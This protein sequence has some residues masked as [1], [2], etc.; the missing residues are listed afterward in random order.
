VGSVTVEVA[1]A[2]SR[3]DEIELAMLDQPEAIDD[4]RPARDAA[5]ADE[6]GG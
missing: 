6:A 1:R 4:L 5:L 2:R 3:V